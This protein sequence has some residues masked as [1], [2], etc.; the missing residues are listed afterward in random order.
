MPLNLIP[1]MPLSSNSLVIKQK[2]KQVNTK[3]MFI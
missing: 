1:E 3:N 2:Q